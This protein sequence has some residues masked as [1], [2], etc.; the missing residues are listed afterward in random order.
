MTKK[1]GV[2]DLPPTVKINMDNYKPYT[3]IHDLRVKA[4]DYLRSLQAKEFSLEESNPQINF[5]ITKYSAEHTTRKAGETKL[6]ITKQIEEIFKQAYVFNVED[7]NKHH[8]I[9]HILKCRTYIMVQN[10][11]YEFLFDHYNQ[12]ESEEEFTED[13]N[14]DEESIEEY[15]ESEDEEEQDPIE[16][17][18][19]AQ[20]KKR[21]HNDMI[22]KKLIE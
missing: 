2:T 20:H 1:G 5:F 4:N 19:N 7:D 14:T 12:V 16:L 13:E 21:N 9:E 15:T 17:E 22:K 10:K 11:L 8:N 6:I 18:Y 3:D